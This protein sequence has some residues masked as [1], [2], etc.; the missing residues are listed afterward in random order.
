[1]ERRIVTLALMAALLPACRDRADRL[2][3]RERAHEDALGELALA[4]SAQTDLPPLPRAVRVAVRRG[5]LEVD[6]LAAWTSLDAA[7]LDRLAPRDD[8][9]APRPVEHQI[10]LDGLRIP[11]QALRDQTSFLIE[12]F[13]E[14]L[15]EARGTAERLARLRKQDL[16]GRAALWIEPD[17]PFETLTRVLYTLGQAQHGD[18]AFAVRSP[19]G[20]RA[21]KVSAPRICASICDRKQVRH[22]CRG[23]S[24]AIAESGLGWRFRDQIQGGCKQLAMARPERALGEA[25]ERLREMLG[26]ETDARIEELLGEIEGIDTKDTKPAPGPPPAAPEPDC[27]HGGRVEGRLDLAGLRRAL[28]ESP[29]EL[30]ACET[31]MLGATDPIPWQELVE[32]ADLLASFGHRRLVFFV[33]FDAQACP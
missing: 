27:P 17:V 33:V 1:M 22:H 30:P 24:V 23:L 25:T 26:A 12:P 16:E 2:A 3:E 5:A 31:A 6:D 19:K 10:Q 18:Y 13:Y 8:P 20:V 9:N 11:P 15:A 32:V 21:L 29:A 7:E 4:A 28:A 14:A